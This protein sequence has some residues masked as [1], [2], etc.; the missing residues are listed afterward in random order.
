MNPTVADVELD[1]SYTP[2]RTEI[3]K[4][5][6]LIK[7]E[8]ACG[9]LDSIRVTEAPI[10]KDLDD[11][12][13]RTNLKRLM[14]D[15]SFLKTLIEGGPQ[16]KLEDADFN[17][18]LPY[19]EQPIQDRVRYILN[20]NIDL[21]LLAPTINNL[22]AGTPQT[23]QTAAFFNQN[24]EAQMYLAD[25]LADDELFR[26]LSASRD[27]EVSYGASA[28]KRVEDTIARITTGEKSADPALKAALEQFF[29]LDQSASKPLLDR[30][31]ALRR[32]VQSQTIDA[33]FDV[34][35]PG[36]EWPE[37]KQPFRA[38]GIPAKD[39][40]R[41][42]AE[43][44]E[45]AEYY[46]ELYTKV[47]ELY[48]QFLPEVYVDPALSGIS[49]GD[50]NERM[51]TNP[52][53]YTKRTD[54]DFIVY[55]PVA[56][57]VNLAN[58]PTHPVADGHQLFEERVEM[59]MRRGKRKVVDVIILAH[60]LTHAMYE[61]KKGPIPPENLAQIHKEGEEAS[62]AEGA[63]QVIDHTI[64]EGFATF[65]ELILSD[66]LI[67]NPTALNLD[68]QDIADLQHNKMS[69]LHTIRRADP[70]PYQE[71][72]FDMF[73]RIYEEAAGPPSNRDYH[74]GIAAI[75]EFILNIDRDKTTRVKRDDPQYLALVAENNP[76]KW[77]DFLQKA[78]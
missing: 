45:L 55:E 64:T 48:Q 14:T 58:V 21:K 4:T 34:R 61:R 9:F 73:H 32:T 3:E 41:R 63:T 52:N 10:S 57:T 75:N 68:Q 43:E 23:E 69:R 72:V 29:L 67:K 59:S 16:K 7:P 71:G 49:V 33:Y 74:K 18:E 15:Q 42:Q 65:M 60:E 77:R 54:P 26:N 78:A 70:N 17:Q 31:T 13:V 2:E 46:A 6:K 44:T 66:A 22:F 12:R 53:V 56:N 51:A 40:I 20:T 36:T 47:N 76:Q 62:F 19:T 11:G 8:A 35:T 39:L 30:V 38:F 1:Q 27:F 50:F 25:L 37:Q 28:K 24:P 5:K